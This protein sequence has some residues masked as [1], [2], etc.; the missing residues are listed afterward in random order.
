MVEWHTVRRTTKVVKKGDAVSHWRREGKGCVDM[1]GKMKLCRSKEKN[2]ELNCTKRKYYFDNGAIFFVQPSSTRNVPFNVS[3]RP[4]PAV[5]LR[6]N[7]EVWL[8]VR[9]LYVGWC[10]CGMGDYGLDNWTFG[11]LIVS[12]IIV[13]WMMWLW[14][15]WL[16]VG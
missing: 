15:A 3:T 6:E 9:R 1:K 16:W 5:I 7:I 10:D 11:D 13:C 4:L 8:S 2:A 14:D 12:R